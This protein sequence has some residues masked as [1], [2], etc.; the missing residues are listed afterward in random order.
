MAGIKRISGSPNIQ[1]FTMASA[2]P[3]VV[4]G[5]LVKIDGNGLVALAST[6]VIGG[7]M[8]SKDP[9]STTTK[10]L[11]DVILTDN[12]EFVIPYKAST[13]AQTI[14]GDYA[15]ITFTSNTLSVDDSSDGDVIIQRLDP[16]DAVGT[17]SGRV[18]VRFKPASL[19]FQAGQA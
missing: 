16:R 18:I 7:I 1:E 15:A 5:D 3:A 11:V 4:Q 10:V 14:V 9:S 2:T 6:G 19:Q 12:S 17:T 13:T 8:K